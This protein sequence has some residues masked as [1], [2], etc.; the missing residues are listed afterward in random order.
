MSR[1]GVDGPAPGPRQGVRVR[2]GT[3]VSDYEY[4]LSPDRIAR[5]P[6]ERRDESRLLVVPPG[7][8]PFQHERFRDLGAL[9]APGDVLVVNESKVLPAR[10][11]GHKPTG[12]P[13]EVLLT[14][15][16]PD[17]GD[18]HLWEAL[19]RPGGKLKP[20][21]TVVVADDLTVE[22]VDSVA[23][24]GRLVRLVTHLPVE[25]ALERYGH[26]PLPP[27]LERAAEPM[28]RERY[29]TV[30]ARAAGSVAAPTAGLHFTEELLERLR[31]QDVRIAAVTLHVGIGTFRPV[32][33]EDPAD[34][35]LHE[36][37]YEIGGEAAGLIRGAKDSGKRVWAVGTTA[38]RTLEAAAD[39]AGGIRPGTGTTNLFIRPP[40]Q[41]RVVDCLLTNFHL[42]RSTL[43]MLVSS[44]G[45]YTR[46]MEAYREAIA[47]G[48]RFYS[49]G[50]AMAVVGRDP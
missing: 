38:V 26:M 24:G 36:E 4:E 1:I 35:E 27:Y 17:S 34:H 43:L 5:Y 21:R 16:A 37:W 6:S 41:F 29:Q 46:I 15:P 3:R 25:E 32:D 23:G 22:I 7:D 44:L 13:A 47:N 12:A 33:V 48:Y 28:D 40:Y 49:Y 14:R 45:G 2:D 11:L 30:Y 8:D 50:D 10:L 31:A 20:G 18:P 42:P 19:V 39:E 9:F